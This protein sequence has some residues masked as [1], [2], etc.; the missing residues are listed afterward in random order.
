MKKKM[1]LYLPEHLALMYEGFCEQKH[2]AQSHLFEAMVQ[3]FFDEILKKNA[4]SEAAHTLNIRR[5]DDN[6]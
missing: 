1:Q 2:I 3:N 6:L 5:Q 4:A